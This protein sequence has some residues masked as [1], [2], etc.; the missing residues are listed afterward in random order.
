[1]G[2]HDIFQIYAGLI[3]HNMLQAKAAMC[4]TFS[5]RKICIATLQFH[6]IS[7]RLM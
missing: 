1:M 3:C 7:C 6:N 4:N 5:L 2:F